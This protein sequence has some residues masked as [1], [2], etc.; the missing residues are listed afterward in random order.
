VVDRLYDDSAVDIANLR[1]D[2]TISE[3]QRQTLVDARLGQGQFRARL[4]QRWDQRCA[5]TGCPLTQV[6][7]AS[8]TRPWRDCNDGERLNPANG[9]LLTANLDA[10][11]DKFLISFCDNGQMLISSIINVECCRMLGIP[12]NVREQLTIEE[13]HFLH[14]HRDCFAA[15]RL[16]PS[17]FVLFDA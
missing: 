16:G 1:R 8:H 14:Y 7:R 6:L 5:V 11:F 12:Q 10:L 17:P 4:L 9:L 13:Q 3:T 2:Q 15:R